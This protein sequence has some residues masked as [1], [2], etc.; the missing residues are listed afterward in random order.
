MSRE[1]IFEASLGYFL[2]PVKRY[3]DDATVTEIMVNGYNDVYIERRGKLEHTD[4][5]F[6]SEDALLTAVHNV[7][8]Y[9]GREIA[10]V[11]DDVRRVGLLERVRR[12]LESRREIADFLHVFAC[13]HVAVREHPSGA[14]PASADSTLITDGSTSYSTFTARAASMACSSV[15]AAT[16]ATSSPWYIT[17]FVLSSFGSRTT[18]DALKPGTR[19]AA[20]K[21]IETTFARGYGERTARA[22]SIPGR[23]TSNVYFARPLTLSGPSRRLTRVPTTVLGVDGQLYFGSTGGACGA[24]PRPPPWRLLGARRGCGGGALA[25]C[26]ARCS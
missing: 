7:A 23:L 6:P 13:A 11:G 19:C 15:S 4:A 5:R 17:T 1:A 9:V 24:P 8:Q 21:S 25:A 10:G 14:R 22:Y 2:T 26:L 12:G 18:S 3:L 16:A 20:E